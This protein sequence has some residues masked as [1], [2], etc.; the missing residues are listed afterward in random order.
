MAE[1]ELAQTLALGRM[2]AALMG[3]GGEAEGDTTDLVRLLL[4]ITR[5]T[6]GDMPE[7][8]RAMFDHIASVVDEPEMDDLVDTLLAAT[9]TLS[10]EPVDAHFIGGPKTELVIRVLT[11]DSWRGNAVLFIFMWLFC[12]LS[13]LILSTLQCKVMQF[14]IPGERA[15]I[16]WL[17][18]QPEFRDNL[19]SLRWLQGNTACL[20]SARVGEAA[21]SLTD[22]FS[23][24]S[25][26]KFGINVGKGARAVGRGSWKLLKYIYNRCARRP[27]SPPSPP[28]RR[29]SPR[30]PVKRRE[31]QTCNGVATVRCGNCQDAFYCGQRCQS[32]DWA[33]HVVKCQSKE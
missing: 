18:K 22:A 2:F 15:S 27:E 10:I 12:L 20:S 21:N 3:G 13:L 16:I 11:D 14:P 31:C 5:Q 17:A 28:H 9:E 23:M 26:I 32:M 19:F 33:A 1:L 29:T 4:S 6:M 24:F 7:L 30:R 8:R 25:T